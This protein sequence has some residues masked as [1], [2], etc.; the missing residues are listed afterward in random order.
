M[1]YHGVPRLST[2]MGL[3]QHYYQNKGMVIGRDILLSDK[4]RNDLPPY[5]VYEVR[6]TYTQRS[7][8]QFVA[9][10]K[11]EAIQLSKRMNNIQEDCGPFHYE[12]VEK[13]GYP[14]CPLKVG[15]VGELMRDRESIT[16]VR[17]KV[18]EILPFKVDGILAEYM[19]ICVDEENRLGYALRIVIGPTREY[20]W[21]KD[22]KIDFDEVL[23]ERGYAP[24]P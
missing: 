12:V 17:V 5:A 7:A 9:H 24:V 21:L 20:Q 15:D 3:A 16:P 22:V 23:K 13:Q 6:A 14:A 8:D 18:D 2:P 4:K 10:S 1:K 19:I 11:E